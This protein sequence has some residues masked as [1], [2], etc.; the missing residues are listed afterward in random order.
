MIPRYSENLS[1]ES[2][3]HLLYSWNSLL[4]TSKQIVQIMLFVRTVY[5][6]EVFASLLFQLNVSQYKRQV[7]VVKIFL[8]HCIAQF[9]TLA[10][11][12]LH[13][14]LINIKFCT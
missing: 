10:D 8:L 7:R 1:V 6:N 4:L 14:T 5:A 12:H 13:V 2:L 3:H 9:S 11:N